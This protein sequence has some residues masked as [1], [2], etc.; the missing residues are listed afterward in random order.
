LYGNP[1]PALDLGIRGFLGLR[2]SGAEG[3]EAQQQD[4]MAFSL[5]HPEAL[6]FL[7]R[8]YGIL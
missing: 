4:E 2:G 8:S 1:T 7:I 6:L 3:A 5:E